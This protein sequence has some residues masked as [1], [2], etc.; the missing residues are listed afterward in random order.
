MPN[1]KPKFFKSL[2][3]IAEC[4]QRFIYNIFAYHD[5]PLPIGSDK[6]KKRLLMGL[7]IPQC[8]H[9]EEQIFPIFWWDNHQG[10]S[11]HVY[12]FTK[13]FFFFIWKILRCFLC[14]KN[15]YAILLVLPFDE[16]SL[17]PVL[18][19]PLQLRILVSID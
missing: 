6:I 10:E 18:S 13:I 14:W 8:G 12:F 5:S 17:W 4:M 3:L 2:N 19:S 16:I 1:S 11:S 9:K 15:I 7:N